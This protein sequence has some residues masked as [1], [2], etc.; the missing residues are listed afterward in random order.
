M[1]LSAEESGLRLAIIGRT[2]ALVLLGADLARGRA[3]ETR[4]TRWTT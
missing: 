3:R 2:V 1:F 4:R